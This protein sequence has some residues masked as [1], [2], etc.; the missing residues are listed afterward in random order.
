MA[1]LVLVAKSTYVWLAQLSRDY[2]RAITRLDQ[3]PD[4]ELDELRARRP[5]DPADFHR[6]VVADDIWRERELVLDELLLPGLTRDWL[7]E[8]LAREPAGRDG[9]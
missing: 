4:E 7:G 9:R 6:A 5:A 2:G 1:E 3:I 8:V